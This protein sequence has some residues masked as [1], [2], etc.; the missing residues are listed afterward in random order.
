VRNPWEWLVSYY[1]F[2]KVTGPRETRPDFC[3][4]FPTFKDWVKTALVAENTWLKETYGHYSYR[5]KIPQHYYLADAEGKILVDFVGRYERLQDDLRRACELAGVP[6]PVK[7]TRGHKS[8]HGPYQD[9]YDEETLELVAPFV[10]KDAEL[11]GY[12]EFQCES[13]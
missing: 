4:R 2:G 8:A 13:I 3:E 1:S 12:Q 7:L 11:F 6:V 10:A 5:V 9:Y